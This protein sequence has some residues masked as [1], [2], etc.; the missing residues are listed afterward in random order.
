[1]N[2]MGFGLILWVLLIA[3]AIWAVMRF[4]GRASGDDRG[5]SPSPTPLEILEERYARGE[6]SDQEFA[7][8]KGTLEQ[9]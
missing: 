5:T 1:M 7:E 4:T 9:R 3:V 8:R 2:M 6:I